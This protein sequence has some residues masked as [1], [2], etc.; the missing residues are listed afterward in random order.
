MAQRLADHIHQLQSELDQY[1]NIGEIPDVY[2]T[3][4]DC[5]T[6]STERD[7]LTEQVA[8]LQLACGFNHADADFLTK[9]TEQVIT[10]NHLVE[11]GD[12]ADEIVRLKNQ[13]QRLAEVTQQTSE[14]GIMITELEGLLSIQEKTSA[15]SGIL[16]RTRHSVDE[17][18]ARIQ[19]SNRNYNETQK[20]INQNNQLQKQLEDMTHQAQNN[21]VKLDNI[22]FQL[23][24]DN[25]ALLSK[26]EQIQKF[27]YQVQQLIE[28]RK[29]LELKKEN[30]RQKLLDIDQKRD[31][32]LEEKIQQIL[33]SNQH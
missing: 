20:L 33:R 5:K 16:E 19:E 28:D 26:E 32:I 14:M 23:F 7:L 18:G 1:K 27:I 3:Y 15:E 30:T 13:E 10:I 24:P 8:A 6:A 29:E 9:H 21:N 4:E 31:K 22:I 2:Q 17:V 12:A 25:D 11:L